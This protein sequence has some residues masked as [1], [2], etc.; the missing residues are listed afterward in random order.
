[1]SADKTQNQLLASL[2]VTVLCLHQYFEALATFQSE[3]MASNSG[4]SCIPP[5]LDQ[6]E[7]LLTQYLARRFDS[8]VRNHAG[9][10]CERSQ[11]DD[12]IPL[13]AKIF[14]SFHDHNGTWNMFSKL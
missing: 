6:I 4:N 7:Q 5:S 1:M 13:L 8:E 11:P 3:L 10:D 14:T 12:L 2:H 9:A